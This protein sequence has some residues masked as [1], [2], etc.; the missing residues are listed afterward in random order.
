MAAAFGM[1]GDG[2]TQ[3]FDKEA[4]RISGSFLPIAVT[5]LVLCSTIG[6][7]NTRA[8]GLEQSLAPATTATHTIFLLALTQRGNG[9]SVLWGFKTTTTSGSTTCR[10]T[11]TLRAVG[12]LKMSR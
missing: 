4:G 8:A 9:A 2:R 6:E 3:V 12:S 1:S 7:G 10:A 11:H 5:G